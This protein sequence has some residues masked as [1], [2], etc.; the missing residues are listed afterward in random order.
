MGSRVTDTVN[1]SLVR[2]GAPARFLG[3]SRVAVARAP[4][5]GALR[6]EPMRPFPKAEAHLAARPAPL[7]VAERIGIRGAVPTMVGKLKSGQA[8]GQATS[9]AADE[10]DG[11]A[12]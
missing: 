11:S 4:V 7:A 1:G 3:R 10:L 12:R 2:K 5:S 6:K 9:W 8:T